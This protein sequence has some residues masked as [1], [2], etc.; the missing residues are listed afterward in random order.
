METGSVFSEKPKKLPPLRAAAQS[1]EEP[2]FLFQC[3]GDPWSPT[4]KL[5]FSG[6]P[7]EK[8]GVFALRRWILLRQNPRASEARPYTSFFDMLSCRPCGRQRSVSKNPKK[9]HVIAN[10]SADWCGD[11]V[12]THKSWAKSYGIATSAVG[13]LAMTC[14]LTASAAALAGGSGG[15]W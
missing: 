7:K 1:V 14:F 9:K 13:L 8:N 2:D 6:F 12:K 4:E 15:S 3:R 10:Q 5:R 11:P